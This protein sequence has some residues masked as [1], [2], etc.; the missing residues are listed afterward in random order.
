MKVMGG[1]LVGKGLA[2][3]GKF[4]VRVWYKRWHRW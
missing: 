2:H 4:F 3:L 1:V